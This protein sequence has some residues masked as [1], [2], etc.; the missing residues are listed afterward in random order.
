[1]K[2]VSQYR[3]PQW[4]L[5]RVEAWKEKIGALSLEWLRVI[6][7]MIVRL[8]L[9]YGAVVWA[10]RA[11]VNFKRTS[12]RKLRRVTC[13]CIT[14]VM[15]TCLMRTME[16]ILDLTPLHTVVAGAAK[17][18][19]LRLGRAGIGRE[20]CIGFRECESLLELTLLKIAW[21]ENTALKRIPRV[22]RS[23]YNRLQRKYHQ[24]V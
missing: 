4:L 15:R 18:I 2:N 19:I 8:K 10:S 22:K 17:L 13:V 16:I 24:M 23:T 6:Y 7:T 20:K 9:I 21:Q 5:W 11:R 14:G 3:K 12:F 1:M